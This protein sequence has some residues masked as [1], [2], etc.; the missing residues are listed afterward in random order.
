MRTPAAPELVGRERE[1]ESI[2]ALLDGA[3]DGAAGLLIT[4][5]A[6]IGKTMVWQGA[7]DAARLRGALVLTARPVEAELPLGYAG[8]GDLLA[9]QFPGIESALTM[10]MRRALAAALQLDPEGEGGDPLLVG[11]ATLAALIEL[12]AT[13]P[14]VAAVD[15]VQW[16]DAA[17]ARALAFGI[18]RLG[19]APVTVVASLRDGHSDPLGLREAFGSR[20][21]ELALAPLSLGALSRVLR[22]RE[23]PLSRRA[24]TRIHERSAGNPFFAIQ[25]AGAADPE[26]LPASIRDVVDARLSLV[27][28]IAGAAV[29]DVA[30][31]GPLPVSSIES[32]ALDAAV[33]A[34][35]LVEDGGT[36]R[37]AHPLLAE[38]AYDRIPPGRRRALHRQAATTASSIEIRARHLALGTDDPDASVA[39]ALDEAARA[40]RMRGAPEAA[41]DLMAHAE[42][43]TPASDV[44]AR[45]RRKVD[46]VDYLFLTADERGARVLL[47]EVLLEGA[48]GVSRARAL[49]QRAALDADPVE[50]VARLEAALAETH[51]D[52]RVR[53]RTQSDLGW[54]RGAWLGDVTR[55]LDDAYAALEAAEQLGD[56]MTLLPALTTA[57][58][59]AYLAGNERSESLFRRAIAL[60]DQ[61]PSS[62]RE[63]SP[64]IA[65]ADERWCRGDL[66]KAALLLEEERRRAT[67]YGDDGLLMRL[68]AFQGEVDIRRGRWHDA[69]T[70]LEL[71]LAD[72]RDWL[73]FN[74]LVRV[75]ILAGRRGDAATVAAI[76]KEVRAS[77]VAQ[78]DSTFGDT[79]E[80]AAGLIALAEGRMADAAAAMSILPLRDLGGSLGVE[81]AVLIPETVA[82]LVEAGRLDDARALIAQLERRRR[83]LDPWSTPAIDLAT[84]LLR[85]GSGDADAA[86]AP[87][88]AAVDAFARLGTPWEL[89]QA[90]MAAGRA[91]RRL[92]RRRDAAAEFE[93]ALEIF[94]RL[95]AAPAARRASDE[96][97]RARPRARHDDAL[98]EA[99]RRVAGHV[100]AGATNREVAAQLFTT[101]ATV[102]AH[103]TRIYSK[104]GVRSRTELARFMSDGRLDA[105]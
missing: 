97:G 49:V 19:S 31:L 103:L 3:T 63:R 34:G 41:A 101:V 47:D 69:A 62:A 5:E 99:E 23:A 38:R 21:T 18:R 10:P 20:L 16:L 77:P 11:R 36:I 89:G 4:G 78:R 50:S 85:L 30:V 52:A 81:Q 29:D 58:L 75:A 80:F 39:A 102:E 95:G 65:F 42:R 60:A 27:P 66:E 9:A 98:T 67:S 8:L 33:V 72:A 71:A 96:I 61:L 74:V 25:L 12:A 43:L 24:V 59:L 68:R 2:G 17:S 104:L 84:G 15:D 88:R 14:V 40:A 28:P 93:A 35:V 37:F 45:A 70:A 94:E 56:P 44:E 73:R 22:G 53:I 90:R 57:G 87:L 46:R 105:G 86:L 48:T 64:R 51:D 13:R 83:Q 6:G 92:G 82:V 76:V 55:G 100:A 1:L 32:S 79:V 26:R 7:L 54:H 91:L